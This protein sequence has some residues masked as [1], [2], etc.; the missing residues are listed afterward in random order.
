MR[1][2]ISLWLSVVSYCFTKAYVMVD[3]ATRSATTQAVN[4]YHYEQLF[5]STY[6]HHMNWL[7]PHV[8]RNRTLLV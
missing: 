2:P 7:L 8:D 6:F 1:T 3:A 5:D 4:D